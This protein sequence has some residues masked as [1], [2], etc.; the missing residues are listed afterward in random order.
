ML[1]VWKRKR[2]SRKTNEQKEKVKLGHRLGTLFSWISHP[3]HWIF[4]LSNFD[5]YP[6]IA[7]ITTWVSTSTSSESTSA[8]IITISWMI[9]RHFTKGLKVELAFFLELGPTIKRASMISYQYP[10]CHF[11][12]FPT[13]TN[14]L[15][16]LLATFL[17]FARDVIKEALLLLWTLG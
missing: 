17:G 15:P 10:C 3:A 5:S 14:D 12:P 6:T 1:W 13:T 16:I 9:H 11:P 7:T 2:I 8:T 4:S